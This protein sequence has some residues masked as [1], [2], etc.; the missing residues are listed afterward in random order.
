MRKLLEVI[1][2]IRQSNSVYGWRFAKRPMNLQTRRQLKWGVYFSLFSLGTVID[3]LLFDKQ[4]LFEHLIELLKNYIVY[5][6]V[7]ALLYVFYLLSF[8]F[9]LR[10][11]Y[12]TKE[13]IEYW[14]KH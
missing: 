9:V 7:A 4:W 3:F 1:K 6:A 11:R 2:V 13:V 10:V 12:I 5:S 14:Q 8:P